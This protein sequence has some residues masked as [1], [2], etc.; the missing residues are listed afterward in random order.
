ML[1]LW[2][3]VKDIDPD[4]MRRQD[5]MRCGDD[6]H[7]LYQPLHAKNGILLNVSSIIGLAV[8]RNPS[9]R[10][11]AM[12]DYGRYSLDT[13]AVASVAHKV[14]AVLTPLPKRVEAGAILEA[15][16][17]GGST[18]LTGEANYRNIRVVRAFLIMFRITPADSP[19]YWLY[20]REM[21]PELVK[22]IKNYG[23][24]SPHA[25]LLPRLSEEA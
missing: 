5:W 8:V 3:G 16:A 14:A 19:Q 13:P 12:E 2:H 25:G 24:S 17:T 10:D 22:K 11:G 15:I 7:R 23:I 20:Y 6:I 9:S 21:S 4:K 18:A 1:Y